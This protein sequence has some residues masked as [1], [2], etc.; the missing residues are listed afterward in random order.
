MSAS[1][2]SFFSLTFLLLSSSL[3]P[4]MSR[5]AHVTSSNQRTT[6]DR[7]KDGARKNGLGARRSVASDGGGAW[8]NLSLG[9]VSVRL[10]FIAGAFIGSD[11]MKYSNQCGGQIWVERASTMPRPP[12]QRVHNLLPLYCQLMSPCYL[13]FPPLLFSMDVTGR[14]PCCPSPVLRDV[15]LLGAFLYLGLDANAFLAPTP[16]SMTSCRPTNQ[17]RREEGG[18]KKK[19]WRGRMTCGLHLVTD[20]VVSTYLFFGEIT[21]DI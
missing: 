3:F 11:V 20:I 14:W 16:S 9:S 21:D 10:L 13:E 1:P 2:P 4:K 15:T 18:R 12:L 5:G 7:L 6:V 8:M 19:G 17:W